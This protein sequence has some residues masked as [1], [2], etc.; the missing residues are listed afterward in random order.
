[1]WLFG[2]GGPL[3]TAEP[4]QERKCRGRGRTEEEGER[5]RWFVAISLCD[6]KMRLPRCCSHFCAYR[7][8]VQSA[9]CSPSPSLSLVRSS[10]LSFFVISLPSSG[11]ELVSVCDVRM[12]MRR[13]EGSGGR[14]NTSES[15]RG[16]RPDKQP[17]MEPQFK[18]QH[19]EASGR[20][21]ERGSGSLK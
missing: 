16:F 11:A 8:W 3:L 2:A 12:Q 14:G 13:K 15:K 5:E 6:D 21:P 1:M 17:E 19:G 9:K 7:I 18:G 20:A 4:M 10:F